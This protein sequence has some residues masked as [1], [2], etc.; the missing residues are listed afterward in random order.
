MTLEFCVSIFDL[1]DALS[2][3]GFALFSRFKIEDQLSLKN[4]KYRVSWDFDTPD[5]P[6]SRQDIRAL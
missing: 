4:C 5:L 3:E 6:S 1:I 2:D